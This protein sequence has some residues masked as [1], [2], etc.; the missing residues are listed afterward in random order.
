MKKIIFDK[1]KYGSYKDF[2]EDVYVQLDGIH[3]LDFED[4][5]NLNYHAD[6]LYEFLY[7]KEDEHYNYILK[8]FDLNE[9]KKQKTYENYQ[10]NIIIKIFQDF[11][12]EHPSNTLEFIND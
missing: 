1:N 3:T 4:Y 12:K 11:A 9:I 5:P 7:Y 6:F 2:F 8:N 10:F